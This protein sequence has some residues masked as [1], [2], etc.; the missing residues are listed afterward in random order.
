VFCAHL[1]ASENVLGYY[2]FQVGTDSVAEL[3]DANKS[4]YLKT[5]VAFPAI[6]L[7]FLAVDEA[8][9][10]Q[11]FGQHLLMDVFSKVAQLSDHVGFYALICF[12]W[13]TIP[14]PFTRA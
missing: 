4:T 14:R 6:N 11:G 9:Q 8:V 10:R 12:R 3:P 7:S 13:M 5:Y 2:A 1:E